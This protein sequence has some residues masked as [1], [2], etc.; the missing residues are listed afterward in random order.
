MR[1]TVIWISRMNDTLV[2]FLRN[3]IQ[4]NHVSKRD[5]INQLQHLLTGPRYGSDTIAADQ[6]E[7][8]IM[9]GH[10]EVKG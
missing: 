3:Y 2:D 6:I 5:L 7:S 8:I 9:L 10:I 1:A 4:N